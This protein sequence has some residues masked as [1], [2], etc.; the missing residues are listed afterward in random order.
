MVAP[1]PPP[2][3]G[4]P[5][6]TLQL[7]PRTHDL[8]WSRSPPTRSLHACD[9]DATL[10]ISATT[11][12]KIRIHLLSRYASSNGQDTN[13]LSFSSN[14]VLGSTNKHLALQMKDISLFQL[15]I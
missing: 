3:R 1:G 6:R 2:T 7:P 13:Y 5:P 4:S 14:K 15:M 12:L 11:L 8:R 9:D 10:S